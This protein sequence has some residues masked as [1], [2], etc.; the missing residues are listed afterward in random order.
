VVAQAGARGVVGGGGHLGEHL[1]DVAL[2]PAGLEP[3]D[4]DERGEERADVAPGPFGGRL[5]LDQPTGG[6]Q[7]HGPKP[8]DHA[9]GRAL[10]GPGRDVVELVEH[11]GAVGADVGDQGPGQAGQSASPLDAGC[12]H[13]EHPPEQLGHA[14]GLVEPP[15]ELPEL[16]QAGQLAR[17]VA[18]GPEGGGRLAQVVHGGGRVGLDGRRGPQHARQGTVGHLGGQ[19]PQPAGHHVAGHG[20]VG[21]AQHVDHHVGDVVPGAGLGEKPDRRHHVAAPGQLQPGPAAGLGHF[22]RVDQPGQV[23]P[24]Q[25]VDLAAAGRRGR[26]QR[27]VDGQ[28]GHVGGPSED[29][30]GQG[31]V[32]GPD[33]GQQGE[34]T[35]AVGSDAA[36]HLLP[37]VVG[38]DPG[39][40]RG[41]QLGQRRPPAAGGHLVGGHLPLGVEL[42]QLLG[43]EQQVGLA[44]PQQ[45]TLHLEPRQGQ[46]RQ[47]S[48]RQHQVG[49]ARQRRGEP[50]QQ[51]GPRRARGDLVHVVDHQRHLAG[52]V[53]PGRLD[54]PVDC[55]VERPGRGHP[56]ALA[57]P[58]RQRRPGLVVGPARQPVLGAP[59]RQPVLGHRLGEQRGLAE[60]GRGDHHRDPQS[61]PLVQP[62]QQPRARHVGALQLGWFEPD[63][64][65]RRR[66]HQLPRVR[67]PAL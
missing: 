18:L 57:Q 40:G 50:G 34:V 25:R 59:W 5:A 66:P 45:V 56:H 27:Q 13:L 6:Q 21:H 39:T 53:V 7:R 61:E 24:P 20:R 42:G 54:D 55:G 17:H 12:V 67:S 14:L 9:A 3:G 11:P 52:R 10:Q 22:G 36:Q 51:P 58:G 19:L 63:S 43:G 28:V 8:V 41:R 65:G 15:G 60:P 49:V 30:G 62:P 2:V 37:Q 32:D 1:V 38:L 23:R 48:A 64:A 46:G 16:G 47:A 35:A 29:G 4:V 26:H 44:Q 31:V 33:L